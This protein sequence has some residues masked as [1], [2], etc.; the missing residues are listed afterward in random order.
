[1]TDADDPRNASEI[2]PRTDGGVQVHVYRCA[3]CRGHRCDAAARAAGGATRCIGV[4][5]GW[6]ARR[7]ILHLFA[8]MARDFGVSAF[9]PGAALGKHSGAAK[10]FFI[11]MDADTVPVPHNLLR[12]VSELHATLGDEQP[13]L[14]GMA[15]CRV[16]S[17]PLCHAAGGAGYGLSAAALSVLQSYL[18]QHYPTFLA[19][20]DKFSYGGEDVAVAFALKKGAGVAVLNAGCMYQHEPLKYRRL[21]AKGDN[22][23]RWPLSTTPAS[24]HKLKDAAELRAFFSCAL[25]D[26]R[27]RPRPSPRSL[28]AP[29]TLAGGTASNASFAVSSSSPAAASYVNMPCADSWHALPV[30]AAGHPG[31]LSPRDGGVFTVRHR[32]IEIAPRGAPA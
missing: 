24:F 18:S 20:V 27:S 2:A 13:Y 26:S 29:F 19:R 28:F 5:D 21:H 8:T 25:Y 22:W 3:E 11:K 17:F 23:V 30:P 14:F 16:V 9:P 6:L 10:R 32:A 1:M 4:R 12:L 31:V 15:A 7:K